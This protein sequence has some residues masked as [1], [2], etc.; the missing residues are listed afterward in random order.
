MKEEFQELLKK[1]S[2]IQAHMKKAQNELTKQRVVG[3]S[4]AGQVKV[5]L[6]GRYDA[7]SVSIDPSLMEGDREVLEELIAGAINDAVRKVEQMSEEKISSI[8]S[9]IPFN[10]RDWKL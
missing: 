6:T 3:V 5:E 7:T 10:P 4:G 8:A 2:E 9:E 1:T